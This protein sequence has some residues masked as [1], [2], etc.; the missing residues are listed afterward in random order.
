MCD[1]DKQPLASR[2]GET[3][4]P[5]RTP[6]ARL[7]A[8]ITELRGPMSKTDLGRR[9]RYDRTAITRAEQG[10]IVPSAAMLARLDEFWR[11]GGELVALR[12]IVVGEEEVSPTNRR[13]ALRGLTLG[14]LAAE[15]SRKIAT[16]D[17]DP[18]SVDEYEMDVHKVAAAYFTTPHQQTVDQLAPS[19]ET[20]ERLLDTRLSAG[21]RK[22]LTNVAGWYAFY[23]GLANFDLGDDE[24]AIGFLRLSTQHADETGDLL[25]SGSSAAI[26]SSVAY[27]NDAYDLAYD[28]AG[29]SQ[30]EAHAYTRPILAGCT[31]RAAA[32]A[33]K[34]GEAR[35]TLQ[36][37]EGNVW[38]GGLMPG[39]NPANAAFAHGFHAVTLASLGDGTRAEEHARV[40]LASQMAGGEGQFVQLAGKWTTLAQTYLRRPYP[41]PEQTADA[42]LRAVAALDGRYSRTV[43]QNA[44]R[45]SRELDGRWPDLPRVKDL[46]EAI[47]ALPTPNR[48]R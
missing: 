40:G 45:L 33:G 24:T 22:R 21:P 9:I 15:L 34:S 18:L 1:R 25:L 11:T 4:A 12:R 31:A 23:L 38:S 3:M 27:F 42:V 13:D 36:D 6:L 37:L 16:A 7:A 48:E 30:A 14:V 46:G 47:A 39:P 10:E 43:V 28:L 5:E 20:V 2:E 32:R 41:E 26:R 29:P 19:W 35:L 8:R 17:P 44:Q